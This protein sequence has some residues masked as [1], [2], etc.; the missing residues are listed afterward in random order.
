M[1]YTEFWENKEWYSSLEEFERKCPIF[2]GVA[3]KFLGYR[4]EWSTVCYN[5]HRI[6]CSWKEFEKFIKSKTNMKAESYFI[7]KG[8]IEDHSKKVTSA[9]VTSNQKS[10]SS[11]NTPFLDV[12][13]LADLDLDDDI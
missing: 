8:I 9:S 2:K 6:N 1:D 7:S 3:E 13:D 4:I 5:G 11:D 10:S 12:E